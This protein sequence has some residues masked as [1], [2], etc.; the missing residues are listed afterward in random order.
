MCLKP[1]I[2][3]RKIDGEYFPQEVACRVCWQCRER[4]VSDWV[5]RCLAEAATSEW[6]MP[7]TM[8][9]GPD[10]GMAAKVITPRDYQLCMKALRNLGLKI[11]YF[12]V[13][14]YGEMKGRAHF[15][16]IIF[17]QNGEPP[18]S[19]F[20]QRV[21]EKWWPHGYVWADHSF[22]DKAVRYCVK[23]TLKSQ[24]EGWKTCSKKPPLG[25]Q[26]FREKARA[27]VEAGVF[28]TSLRYQP[29]GGQKGRW[30]RMTGATRRDFLDSLLYSWEENHGALRLDTLTE[31]MV[32]AIDAH[33]RSQEYGA[34]IERQDAR[35]LARLERRA[36]HARNPRFVRRGD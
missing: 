11:R 28:P 6:T 35:D 33:V 5:G 23:Y 13:G 8:T 32:N 14:E 22:Q 2:I 25:Q 34:K 3:H 29:P 9:Y 30:Y 26:W 18:V 15:H 7:L 31:E 17:G 16:C 36:A 4:A 27:H 19:A 10:A 20:N 24:A 21:N 12:G 1:T